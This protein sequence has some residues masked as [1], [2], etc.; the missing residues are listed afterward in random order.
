MSDLKRLRELEAEN[1]KL[2]CTFADLALEN[3][4]MKD[5][6]LRKLLG[7]CAKRQ[8]GDPLIEEHQL[9]AQRACRV[10]WPFGGG[11]LPAS[12]K[13]FDRQRA[14][15]RPWQHERMNR[16]YCALQLSLPGR[17]SPR[18]P[19]RSPAQSSLGVGLH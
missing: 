10:V 15:G 14:Q 1:A 12:W 18:L 17:L 2:K 16:V 19:R 3:A 8:L 9:P 4:A 5:V 6:L 7:P 13:C 11:V